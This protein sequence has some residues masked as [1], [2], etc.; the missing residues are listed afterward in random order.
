MPPK[1]YAKKHNKVSKREVVKALGSLKPMKR[2][3]FDTNNTKVQTN[4]SPWILVKPYAIPGTTTINAA[5]A[6]ERRL[7]DQIWVQR[8]SGFYN[9]QID[10]KT[11]NEV[12]IRKIVG[13]YKGSTSGA[14]KAINVLNTQVLATDFPTRLSRYDP[15]NYKII[16]DKSWT[17]HPISIYNGASA[18][19]DANT[20][21]AVWKS[22]MIKA[23]FNFGRTVRFSDSVEHDDGDPVLAI[24]SSVGWAPFI[25]LQVRCPTLDFTGPSGGG[26]NPSPA[27]DTKFT[28]YFKDAL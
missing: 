1:K 8:C 19:G 22:Q 14:D 18:P 13:W 23:N 26:N 21:I 10:A 15:D 16:E 28:T 11:T 24:G 9:L 12:E 5:G 20:P 2:H 6:N 7:S 17:S 4:S 27:V 25:A 3:P